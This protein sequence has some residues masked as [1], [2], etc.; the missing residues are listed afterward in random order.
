MVSSDANDKPS[1][2]LG[3]KPPLCYREEMSFITICIVIQRNRYEQT[4]DV[5]FTYV[6]AYM[7]NP[8]K[9]FEKSSKNFCNYYLS[10]DCKKH[11]ILSRR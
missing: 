4:I 7:K 8:P 5:S 9:V 1:S 6:Y 10:E 2:L 3:Y 11:V